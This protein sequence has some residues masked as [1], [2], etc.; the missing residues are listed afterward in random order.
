MEWIV[1]DVASPNTNEKYILVI[2]GLKETTYR[3]L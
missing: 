2:M 1:M 3:K